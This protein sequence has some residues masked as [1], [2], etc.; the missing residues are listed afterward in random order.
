MTL[1]QPGIEIGRRK[2]HAVDQAFQK[3]YI[4]SRT[5]DLVCR[6]RVAHAR[7]GSGP[8]R[9]P[10]NQLGDHRIVEWRDRVPGTH[11]GIDAYRRRRH[12]P[13]TVHGKGHTQRCMQMLK[14]ADRWQEAFFRILGIDA[15]FDRM[16]GNGQLRLAKR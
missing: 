12:R 7:Q 1:D 11:A 14:R 9:A 8:V 6:Q 15:R 16:A 2:R 3:R 5:D 10:D 13:G 4:G